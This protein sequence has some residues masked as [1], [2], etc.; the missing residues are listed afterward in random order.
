MMLSMIPAF[1]WPCAAQRA[2]RRWLLLGVSVLSMAYAPSCAAASALEQ[3]REFASSTRA[4]RGEFTQ[5][6]ALSNGRSGASS[7]GT[8]AF[9]RPGR[10][11]W[12]VT[13]PIEQVIVTDGERVHFYD[14]DLRQVT[15]RKMNEAIGS[16]PAAILFGSND[17]EAN[18][19]IKDAGAA[20]G[21]DWLTAQP[22]SK[23]SGFELIRIGFKAGLPEAM[24]VR[25][26]F[27][28]TTR[29]TF[30]A[31]ERNPALDSGLF[32]F[33]APKGVDVIQ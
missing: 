25:D 29:F 21:L 4:A 13:R 30:R 9:I 16:T 22:R 24:D 27:G 5:V 33:V 7:S 15:V 28:Q 20:D 2:V 12:E 17:L 8:F 26:A 32:R 1:F 23:E 18:F 3:L 19:I 14:K 6:Q 11:R 10:F 31:I